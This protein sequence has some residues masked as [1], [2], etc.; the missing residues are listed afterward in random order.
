MR[1]SIQPSVFVAAMTVICS[2]IAFFVFTNIG[3]TTTELV[4]R[5]IPTTVNSLRL[6]EETTSLVASVPKLMAAEN[7]SRRLETAEEI[8]RLARSLKERIERLRTL[9]AGEKRVEIDT[10]Q[11]ALVERLDALD[12]AVTGRILVSAQRQARALSIRR[13]HEELLEGLTPAIDDANFDLM[14]KTQ[15]AENKAASNASLEIAAPSAR[16]KRGRQSVGWAPDRSLA[17]H[18]TCAPAAIA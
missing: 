3:G 13:A 2:L 6:A 12:R 14:T 7:E 8:D 4:S 11:I 18:R 16:S 5:S 15:G 10:A 1:V 9:D 17:G